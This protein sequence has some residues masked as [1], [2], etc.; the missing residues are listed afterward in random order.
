MQPVADS[1][2]M[3]VISYNLSQ[4]SFIWQVFRRD[5]GSATSLGGGGLFHITVST[6]DVFTFGAFGAG[7]HLYQNGKRLFYIADPT[8]TSGAPAYGQYTPTTLTHN[9]VS[10]W[11]GYSGVQKDGI[12]TKQAIVIPALAGD[13]TSGNAGTYI[14]TQVLYEGNAQLL[15]GNVYKMWFGSNFGATGKINYAEST[16]GINWTRRGSAVI[17]G[18]LGPAIIKVSGTYYMY[19][20]S[21]TA[22]GTGDFEVFTSTD[23]ISWSLQNA[24]V[25]SLGTAGQWDSSQ[26]FTFAPIAK[27]G[28]TWYAAYS[29][30]KFASDLG[31]TGLATSTDLI[32]W[33]KY[34]GNPVLNGWCGQAFYNVGGTWYT[35]TQNCQAGQGSAY[36][37]LDPTEVIRYQSKDLITWTTPVHSVHHSQLQEAMNAN[38]GQCFINCMINIGGKA[39]AYTNSDANDGG[40]PQ[41]YQIGLAT[42]P[43]TIENLVTAGEDAAQ[44]VATD[45]FTRA[46]GGLG[47]NWST[48][49]GGTGLQIASNLCEPSATSTHCGQY[50]SGATFNADQYSEIT[51]SNLTDANGFAYPI[52][53]VQP[54]AVSWYEAPIQ[55][56]SDGSTAGSTMIYK[57]VNGT[58]TALG[59]LGGVTFTPSVGDVFRLQVTTGSDG[60]PLLQVFQNGFLIATAQDYG[61]TFTS[62]SPGISQYGTVVTKSQLSAWAGG[63][64]GVIPGYVYSV[65]DCRVAPAGP[66]APRN[67]NGTLTYDVQTSSNHAI[68]PVD[69]RTAGAPVDSRVSPNIP[70]NSRTP[71]TYGPGE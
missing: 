23:G 32:N 4:S 27:I 16:D 36:P 37:G 39:Y 34:G 40:T 43:T 60:F 46:N 7:L 35:W 53:R 58:E 31:S 22:F 33:T 20:Q 6:G 59:P 19:T 52:V 64:A 63:N 45:N 50:Y 9:Q 5:A 15:S 8:Y 68:P 38:T 10:A 18:Q 71:G 44:T 70:Q 28:G 25:I 67:V 49:T 62:G 1:G 61:N 51:I 3:A 66:N 30:T 24:H 14:P 56:P 21:S 57:M 65:P 2:Y 54:G 29:A 17:S 47:S 41:V 42:A 12:W 55:G 69:S 26:M 13:L 48:P 11:R